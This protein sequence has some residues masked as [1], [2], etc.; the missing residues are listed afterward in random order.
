LI[1][2][3]ES[4]FGTGKR[5]IWGTIEGKEGMIWCLFL[6]RRWSFAC[7]IYPKKKLRKVIK[8]SFA[9][10]IHKKKLRKTIKNIFF[11]FL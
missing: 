2:F 8:S 3:E 4:D 6:W 7:E 9:C 11:L 10:G 1:L 5:T